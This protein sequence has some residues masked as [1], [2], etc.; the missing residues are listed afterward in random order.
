MGSITPSFSVEWG[1]VDPDKYTVIQNPGT[2]TVTPN[3]TTITVTDQSATEIYNGSPH[4][5]SFNVTIEGVPA[6]F[7][8]QAYNTGE[9]WEDAG[10]YTHTSDILIRNSDNED[11][12]GYFTGIQHVAGTLTVNKRSVTTA[13]S[14]PSTR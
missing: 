9:W 5:H 10:E 4:E 13:K 12:T 7:T 2:L 14:S 1:G 3:T 6:G 8:A 11:V